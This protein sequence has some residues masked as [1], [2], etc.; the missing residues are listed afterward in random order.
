MTQA[1]EHVTLI[2]RDFSRLVSVGRGEWVRRRAALSRWRARKF[3]TGARS[4]RAFGDPWAMAYRIGSHLGLLGDRVRAPERSRQVH[5]VLVR[6]ELLN[7][8]D[9]RGPMVPTR[10]MGRIEGSRPGAQRDLAVAVNGRVWAVGRSFHLRGRESELFSLIFPERALHRGDNR[11][12]LLEVEPDG[13]LVSL[14]EV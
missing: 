5:G 9:P 11:L 8:V 10:V 14:A 13:G 7:R 3:G 12:Q 1:R 2:R 6:P 4:E